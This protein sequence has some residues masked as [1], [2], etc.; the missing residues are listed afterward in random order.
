MD[1]AVSGWSPVIITTRMPARSQVSRAARASGRGGSDMPTRPSSVICDSAV[2]GVASRRLATASTRSASR[3]ICCAASRMRARAGASSGTGPAAACSALHAARM[4]SGAPLA[5]ATTPSLPACSVVMRFDSDENGI[6]CTRGSAARRSV[7]CSPALA[8]ATTSA[9]S[10][11]SP[12]IVHES[13]VVS[14]TRCASEARA[15]AVSSSRTGPPSA[16][17]V[18]CAT[19][20]A[21][22]PQRNSP[23]GA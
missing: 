7:L 13:C 1:S 8:A 11:G 2:A 15:P 19:S 16:S 17:V 10:V 3:A 4:I 5:K 18:R 22:S 6:S 9:P 14:R 21:A 23:S 20:S 12:R